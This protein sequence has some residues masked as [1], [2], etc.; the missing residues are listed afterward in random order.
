MAKLTDR[1]ALIAGA[2]RGCG[3]GLAVALGDEGATVYVTGRTVRGGAP[4]PDGAP[5]TIDD[6]A[7][8]V[9][10]R[11]GIGIACAVD[12]TDPQQV[13][14]LFTRIGEEQ[15]RLDIACC[16]TWGGNERYSD[17]LWKQPFWE[18][19]AFVW[20]ECMGPG[21]EAFWLMARGAASLMTPKNSGLIVAITEPTLEGAF[22][23]MHA[24]LS[25]TL[26][27]LAHYAINGLVS[28][29]GR[30]SKGSGVAV[31]GL[32]PGFMRTERVRMGLDQMSEAEQKALRYDLSETPEYAGRAVAALAID[33]DIKDQSGR[34]LYVAD[35]AEKYGFTDV[36]GKHIGNFYRELGL[37]P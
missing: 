4:P 27:G 1:V 29:L 26:W 3:R 37:V 5:G 16:A 21:P 9:T 17:P 32:L 25:Q 18:Q 24:S 31:I 15:G 12:F 10:K 13:D 14:A 34:L 6:T 28:E 30:Q 20:R 19:P 7:E 35:L 23:G 11:G 33:P 2:S 8:E 22:E 36:D